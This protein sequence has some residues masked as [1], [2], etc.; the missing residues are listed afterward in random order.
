MARGTWL[1]DPEANNQLQKAYASTAGLD[2]S[3]SERRSAAHKL[4]GNS[5]FT[6]QSKRSKDGAKDKYL[7]YPVARTSDEKTGDTLRIKCV[8]YV[9]PPESGFGVGVKGVFKETG[10]GDKKTVVSATK[11]DRLAAGM[12][13]GQMQLTTD[14]TDANSRISDP[15]NTKTKYYIELPI[16]QEVNDSNSVTWGEDRMNAIELAT[17]SIAQRAMETGV[18]DVGSLA[19]AG[20][21]AFNEGVNI[22]GLNSE[23]QSSLRAAISGY[24]L[25]AL[26]SQVSSKSVISRSTGQILN[27]N[28]ELLFSGV[29]LRSFPFTFTF[30]PRNPK[31]SDVVKAIIRSLKMSMAAKAGEFNGSAQGIFLKSPDL[32]QLDYLKDGKN[33]PFLN[34]FKLCALTGM[35]VNYT[36]AGT[37]ASYSDGTPVNIRMNCTFKEINP[38]YHEDY[39]EG[40]SGDG[41]G[42]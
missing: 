6:K 33:H 28:L 18:G 19:Q 16:P 15:Q 24:A 42:F 1:P 12:E 40:V 17:L 11:E 4:V 36:N 38:I 26:G 3:Q 32:F 8:E 37:Y 5:K 9:P 35:S 29:N 7:S 23:T 31:E 27:N 13:N 22:P 30:S 41:V 39:T 21:Q 10:S 20:I 34:R 25:N 14:F 2:L